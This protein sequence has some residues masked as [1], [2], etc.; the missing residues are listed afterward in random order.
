MPIVLSTNLAQHLDIAR[1]KMELDSTTVQ[2]SAQ[3]LQGRLL[4]KAEGYRVDP[5]RAARCHATR[6]A[7]TELVEMRTDAEVGIEMRTDTEEGREGIGESQLQIKEIT[8]G[9]CAP[10]A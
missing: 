7:F 3:L 1:S 4:G 6:G 5:E 9:P 8:S 2:C 10:G